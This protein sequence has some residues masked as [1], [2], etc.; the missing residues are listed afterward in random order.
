M[1]AILFLLFFAF[2]LTASFFRPLVGVFSYT[3]FSVM[4]PQMSV[5]GEP[6]LPYIMLL[7]VATVIGFVFTKGPKFPPNT[8][9]MVFMI[10]LFAWIAITTQFAI[11]PDQ[12]QK[13]LTLTSKMMMM[14]IL[15][16]TLVNTRDRQHALVW[17][18]MIAVGYHI[19]WAAL[20]G[21]AS[22]GN[23]IV[24]GDFSTQFKSSNPFSRVAILAVPML[25]ILYKTSASHHIRLASLA[26][27][28]TSVMAV[29]V[30]GSR[31]GFLALAVLA[32][33]AWLKSDRKILTAVL[34]AAA[35]YAIMTFA[36]DN[37]LERI[38]Q[39]RDFE[40]VSSAQQRFQVWGYGWEIAK[41]NPI[42]GG[43]FEV[44]RGN[45]FQKVHAAHSIYFELLGEHGFV[46]FG[47]FALM[48]GAMFLNMLKVLKLTRG[49]PEWMWERTTAEAI[50]IALLA[51]LAGGVTINQAF[52]QP[53][54]VIYALAIALYAR[55]RNELGEKAPKQQKS[56]GVATAGAT[57]PAYGTESFDNGGFKAQRKMRRRRYTRS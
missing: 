21:V 19:A 56:S 4:A 44:F 38:G 17:V 57:A 28:L 51:F 3:I 40:E 35:G 37:Q 41:Q 50:I 29:F 31:G 39:I 55:V 5:W 13:H 49:K 43:G 24:M 18:F 6:S 10:A 32:G 25:Y 53:V 2:T 42:T 47:I 16:A 12:A 9:A 20:T 14:T 54:Y 8:A 26:G 46:G 7:A 48:I 1:S 33:F 45:D 30:S 23:G 11:F 36:P 27:M 22:G 34:F 15:M 52:W